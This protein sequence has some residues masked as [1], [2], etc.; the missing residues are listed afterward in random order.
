MI[1][2]QNGYFVFDAPTETDED[3]AYGT[4]LFCVKTL[5]GLPDL[6][7]DGDVD[8]YSLDECY[9]WYR[10][11]ITPTEA[12]HRIRQK[13]KPIGMSEITAFAKFY[14]RG[15]TYVVL[16]GEYNNL[17]FY[18]NETTGVVVGPYSHIGLTSIANDNEWRRFRACDL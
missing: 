12:N 18:F 16:E 11:G 13:L 17:F 8:G 14:F 4:W 2:H 9:E 1:P 5:T 6:D 7:G 15:N 3:K 10:Q